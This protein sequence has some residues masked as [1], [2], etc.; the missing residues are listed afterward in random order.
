[1]V[2]FL[3]LPLAITSLLDWA[4]KLERESSAKPRKWIMMVGRAVWGMQEQE[5]SKA[6]S[7]LHTVLSNLS[8][9]SST[10]IFQ[11]L[12]VGR[13]S[14]D[15]QIQHPCPLYSTLD[16]SSHQNKIRTSTCL[17]N[18]A[19]PISSYFLLHL[20]LLKSPSGNQR[21][22]LAPPSPRGT[23]PAPAAT[24]MTFLILELIMLPT[25]RNS[26]AALLFLF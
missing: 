12:R 17:L 21:S 9:D 3:L 22:V 11:F 18:A 7:T 4:W 10:Q 13:T 26:L 5:R 20:V 23:L 16:L 1:M 6:A 15:H 2:L 19:S 24:I 14:P 8:A 25:N